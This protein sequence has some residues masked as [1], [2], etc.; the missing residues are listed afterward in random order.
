[1]ETSKV[2]EIKRTQISKSTYSEGE[3]C[4]LQNAFYKVA[5]FEIIQ[6]VLHLLGTIISKLIDEK[7]GL[8]DQ[9]QR[10]RC[11]FCKTPSLQRSCQ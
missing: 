7:R 6:E 5:A 4:E 8:Q 9:P 11:G 2:E 10:D 3:R 1:M